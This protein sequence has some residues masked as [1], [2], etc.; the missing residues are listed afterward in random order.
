MSPN[1]PKNDPLKNWQL[2]NSGE[3]L[4]Q[5][6]LQEAEQDLTRHLTLQPDEAGRQSWQPVEYKRVPGKRQIG[7]ILPSIVIVALLLALGYVAWISLGQSGLEPIMRVATAVLGPGAPAAEAPGTPTSEATAVAVAATEQPTEAP[8]QVPTATAAPTEAPTNTPEPSPTPLLVV[9][10]TIGTVNADGG[11]NTRSQPSLDGILVTLVNKGERVVV[12]AEQGDWLQVVLPDGRA[13]WA[14]GEF[15]DRTTETV[16][17]EEQNRLLL[18]A[19]LP[20]LDASAGRPAETATPEPVVAAPVP[21]FVIGDPG[22]SVRISPTV[23]AEVVAQVTLS[24]TLSAVGRSE[25]GAWYLVR[26][27]D[28]VL[29]WVTGEFVTP[30]GDTAALP[31]AAAEIAVGA[32]AGPASPA[33]GAGATLVRSPVVPPEP[34]TNTVPVGPAVAIS[35]TVG[36][37]ARTQPTTT[38]VLVVTI[39][40]GA[41]LPVI[42]RTPDGSWLQIELPTGERAWVAREVVNVS[43]DVDTAP[44]VGEGQ[45]AAEAT[46]VETPEPP[47]A[48]G[49]TATVSS[50]LGAIIRA[51]PDADAGELEVAARGAT[52]VATGRTADSSWVQVAL[53]DGALGWIRADAVTLDVDLASLPVVP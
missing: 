21:L 40:N 22:V 17:L 39:P 12:V 27:A 38:G 45:P 37:N 23:D 48:G 3:P 33:E 9:D 31:L 2:E 8:T 25:D 52:L 29:G 18:A 28:D 49:A 14:L 16:P 47:P 24:S 13:A 50:L 53:A 20:L 26:T 42:G 35:D 36:V 4:D 32:G 51:Q 19:G 5:W 34:Y 15:F 6:K 44:V 1:D 41:V 10:R 7:W 46:P 30:Q 11:V 43:S